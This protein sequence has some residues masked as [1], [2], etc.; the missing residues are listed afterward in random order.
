MK[1]F[2]FNT[3]LFC[4]LGAQTASAGYI[5]QIDD[6]SRENALGLTGGGIFAWGNQ[7]SVVPGAEWIT[8]VIIYFDANSF[9]GSSVI[10]SIYA[11]P[12]QNA[13]PS[14]A[15]P[16]ANALGVANEGW[17]IFAFES[18]VYVGPAGTSFFAVASAVH[19]NGQHPAAF[20]QSSDALRSWASVS[21]G[22]SEAGSIS[23]DYGYAGNFMIRAG[24]GEATGGEIPE[25][26]TAALLA[27]AL[28]AL[29]ALARRR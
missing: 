15:V 6:G 11:D 14:D 22:F 28:L 7:Y 2:V 29:G 10:G 25:P 1:T 24:S 4:L 13:H 27:G 18:P 17:T 3:L 19:S 16:L 20:D 12:D 9:V 8:H 23:L 26:G 5:Y 21:A